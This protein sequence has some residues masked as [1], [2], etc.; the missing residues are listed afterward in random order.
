[1]I[2]SPLLFS[3]EL[4]FASTAQPTLL[5]H[6]SLLSSGLPSKQSSLTQSLVR[7]ARSVSGATQQAVAVSSSSFF[8][9]PLHSL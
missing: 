9:L 6:W 8:A 2:E 5:T 4:S 7:A 3:S 1:M